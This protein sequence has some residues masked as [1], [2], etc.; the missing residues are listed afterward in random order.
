MSLSVTPD[1]IAT[2]YDDD[3]NKIK[4]D[5]LNKMCSTHGGG[6]TGIW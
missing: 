5:D 2:N 3:S 4:D 6:E 1:S